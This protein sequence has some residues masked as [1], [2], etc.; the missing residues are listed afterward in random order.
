MSLWKSAHLTS[1]KVGGRREGE[2][3]KQLSSTH[4]A[5]YHGMLTDVDSKVEEL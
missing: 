1:V 5:T 2:G 4:R 3:G